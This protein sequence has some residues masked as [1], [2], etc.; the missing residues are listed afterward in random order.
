MIVKIKPYTGD[1]INNVKNFNIRLKAKGISYQFHESDIPKWLPKIQNRK[2]FQEFFLAIDEESEVRG[3]FVLKHQEFSIHG[4][5]KTIVHY[6]LPISEGII[7]KAYTAVG[8]LIL[9][10]ALKQQPLLFTLG[11]GS[12]EESISKILK[13]VGWSMFSVPFYFKIMHPSQF[14]RNITFL[15]KTSY[16]QYIFD[17]LAISGIGHV[18][19]KILQALNPKRYYQSNDLVLEVVDGFH[20]WADGLWEA[21]QNVY[22]MIAVRDSSTLNILYPIG[23]DRF[24]RLKIT[25]NDKIIGWAV[26]LDTMMSNHKQ[27][28]NMRVD[29]IIDCLSLPENANKVIA[30]VS[31]FLEKRGADIIVSNQSHAS[32]CK[33]LK[34]TGY[35]K[36]P[37]NF[38]FAASTKLT[39]CLNPYDPTGKD[40]HLN[41]GDGDGPINL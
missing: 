9:R 37:S 8:S 13:A 20:H 23:N 41:R 29:S 17:F 35:F 28:G 32:W 40:I 5:V 11:M 24:I 25:E 10:Y 16:R 6:Q 39:E 36:G 21:C 22:S 26:V 2:I 18:A 7:D 34:N 38:I 4:D 33:A 30:C 3:A 12:Y 1:M 19:I 27:F 15:R 14:L 31:K